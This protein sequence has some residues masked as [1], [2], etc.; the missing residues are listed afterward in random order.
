MLPLESIDTTIG[1]LFALVWLL[2]LDISFRAPSTS[3][4]R[5]E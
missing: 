1:V 5:S 2:I 4:Q 3:T